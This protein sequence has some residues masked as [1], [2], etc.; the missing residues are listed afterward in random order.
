MFTQKKRYRKLE[1]DDDL[2]NLVVRLY[3][4]KELFVF[5]MELCYKLNYNKRSIDK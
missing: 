2:K 5:K 4:K 3:E 1:Y